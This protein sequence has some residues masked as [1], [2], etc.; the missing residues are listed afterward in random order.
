[1][2]NFAEIY[3]DRLKD[4][5]P[6]DDQRLGLLFE[7]FIGPYCTLANIAAQSAEHVK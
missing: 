3:A 4:L 1:M 6:T 2:I 5:D 7:I